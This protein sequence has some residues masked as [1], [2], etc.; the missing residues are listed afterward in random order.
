MEQKKDTFDEKGQILSELFDKVLEIESKYKTD[1]GFNIF[2]TL[3]VENKEV[4]ICRFLGELLNPNGSHGQGGRFLEIF[5]AE[6]LHIDPS[7]VL[8]STKGPSV[9]LEEQIDS[10]RRVD[11]VIH[12]GE[13]AASKETI[14]PI[15][16][17]IWADDQ[18]HQLYDYYQYY[19]GDD[20]EKKIYYL[21]PTGR[22]PSDKSI[23]GANRKRLPDKNIGILSFHEHIINW[24]QRI[25]SW[26]KDKDE[27]KFLSRII[28]QF[29]EVIG[30]MSK[31]VEFEKM[32]GLTDEEADEKYLEKQNAA[33]DLMA[34]SDALMNRIR[35]EH[36]IKHIEKEFRELYKCE[37]CDSNKQAKKIDP[38]ALVAIKKNGKDI[39]WI[40]VDT[41]LYL[42]CKKVKDKELFEGKDSYFWQ[43]IGPEKDGKKFDVSKPFDMK[44]YPKKLED[45]DVIKVM[46]LLN[47]IDDA[48]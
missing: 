38:H 24:L 15:E 23:I 42:C 44:N 20:V 22:M 47:Q 12:G 16:V 32:L 8:H 5:L 29:I 28:E 34:H 37:R 9:K 4:I 18:K 26:L 11:I 39:A 19:F 1:S 45:G 36:I 6:V 17:K 48:E 30:E 33:F 21:T 46:E 31:I 35:Q 2:K 14:L 40:C 27:N 3:G 43:Y 13:Y 25:N 7:S 10:E 41:N